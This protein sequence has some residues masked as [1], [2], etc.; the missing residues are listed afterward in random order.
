MSQKSK[1]GFL[2]WARQGLSTELKVVDQLGNSDKHK[3]PQFDVEIEVT[4]N[5]EPIADTTIKK[6]L[7]FYEPGDI[8]GI[9]QS[10]IVKTNPR[11][12]VIHFEPNFFPYIEFYDADFAWRYT[13]FKDNNN[14][15]RPWLMLVVLEEHEFQRLPIQ[16]EAVLPAISIED[17]FNP[18]FPPAS[19]LWAWAHVQVNPLSGNLKELLPTNKSSSRI[20]CPRKL[21]PHTQ[22]FAFLLPSFERGRRAGLMYTKNEV[23]EANIQ[24]PAWGDGQTAFPC[25]YEWSF[26]T[27]ENEDFESLVQKIKARELDP[28]VGKRWI[29]LQ[30]GGYGL[31]YVDEAEEEGFFDQPIIED[32][33]IQEETEP[34]D[35]IRQGAILMEG[36]LQV[37]GSQLP[38]LID[39]EQKDETYLEKLEALLNL[40]EDLKSS[41]ELPENHPAY[42]DYDDPIVLPPIYGRWYAQKNGVDK[43]QQ[44]PDWC[45]QL[46]LDPR[47]RVV[48][49][50]GAEVVRRNQEDYMDRAWKQFDQLFEVNEYLRKMKFSLAVNQSV[51]DKH[52]KKMSGERNLSISGGIQH[53]AQGE[54]AESLS[55]TI[56]N[57]AIPKA[58]FSPA[59]EKVANNNKGWVKKSK[60]LQK[61]QRGSISLRSISSSRSIGSFGLYKE[62]PEISLSEDLLDLNHLILECCLYRYLSRTPNDRIDNEQ[63]KDFQRTSDNPTGIT[64]FMYEK[65]NGAVDEV[66]LDKLAYISSDSGILRHEQKDFIEKLYEHFFGYFSIGVQE[67]KARLSINDLSQHLTGQI[68]P[69]VALRKKAEAKLGNAGLTGENFDTI[70]AAPKF[71]DAMA[72]RLNEIGFE[73]LVSNLDLIPPN[74]YGLMVTNAA[75]AEAF[76]VGANHEMSRELLWRE[77]PTDQRGT[78]FRKFWESRD[79]E[80]DQEDI[81]PIHQWKDKP[82]GKNSLR[83]ASEGGQVVIVLRAD[84]LIRFHNVVVY[85]QNAVAAGAG[86]RVLGETVVWPSFFYEIDPDIY[87]IGFNLSQEDAT[88]GEG[89]FLVLKERPGEMQFGLDIVANPRSAPDQWD[90]LNWETDLPGVKHYIDLDKEDHIPPMIVREG[91][92]WGNGDPA[93]GYPGN[94]ANMAWILQQKPNSVAVHISTLIP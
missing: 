73:N 77:F 26:S 60:A 11:P 36:A 54:A 74:T 49:G 51:V 45:N 42:R 9:E 19:Q 22:Y 17:G 89:Y 85:L 44:T 35:T 43:D 88:A 80:I 31:H 39:I 48:A 29:D 15:L 47:Y 65:P 4:G 27:G 57:K 83:A 84:L 30:D 23:D 33:E 94:A 87:F 7:S 92:P 68:A 59:M 93:K 81:T 67:P 2:P 25:Y 91:I 37:W 40:D 78:Y 8:A 1:Y 63:L 71:S 5:G 6:T 58:F 66:A 41:G 70:L 82:L 55:T 61:V 12:D 72:A 16:K 75:F 69:K 86:K 18:P 46:N 64:A 14:R 32:G 53:I 38:A 76:M 90:S 3:L 13:P 52:F 62:I 79:S 20:L 34:V 56:Y 21:K 10:A 28:N 24:A 50:L